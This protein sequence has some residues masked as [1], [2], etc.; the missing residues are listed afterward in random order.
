MGFNPFRVTRRTTFD[1]VLVVLT[2]AITVALLVWAI[3][4]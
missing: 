2:L 1:V 3:R 4:G